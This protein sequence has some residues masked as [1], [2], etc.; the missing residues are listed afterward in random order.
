MAIA[1]IASMASAADT[2]STVQDRGQMGKDM[3][4]KLLVTQLKN[5][6]PLEPME[7][8]EFIAQLA[9]MN[10][11]EQLTQLNGQLTNFL[12]MQA[13]SQ[14]SDLVGKEVTISKAD[15]T[16]IQGKVSKVIF[17][18]QTPQVEVNG[19]LYLL[20]QVKELRAT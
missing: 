9:T 18:G 16:E 3:F 2:S 12:L 13:A 19:E 11:A 1:G 8:R 7:D 4:L 6:N 17:N 14:A 20:A 5:Q 15:G 10:S